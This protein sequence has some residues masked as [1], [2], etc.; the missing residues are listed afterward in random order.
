[1]TLGL[2]GQGFSHVVACQEMKG[3][4]RAP[5][6]AEPIPEFEVAANYVAGGPDPQVWNIEGFG[7]DQAVQGRTDDSLT[8][9]HPREK[10]LGRVVHVQI[11]DPGFFHHAENKRIRPVDIM[12]NKANAESRRRGPFNPE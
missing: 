3:G 8:L 4:L 12:G 2:V 7:K 11:R 6:R 5:S 9:R 10:N 1:M